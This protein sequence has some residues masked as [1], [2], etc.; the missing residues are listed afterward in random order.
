MASKRGPYRDP[1]VSF[2][3]TIE[4][5]ELW[6]DWDP[7]GAR[8]VPGASPGEYDPYLA[9]TMRLLERGASIDEIEAYLEWIAF[10]RMGLSCVWIPARVFAQALRTWYTERWM[11]V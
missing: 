6:Q 11:H 9:P 8:D 4:V 7:V 1:E 3:Q 2:Q 5:R 10:K